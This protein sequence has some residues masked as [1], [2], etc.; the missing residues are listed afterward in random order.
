M[1][2]DSGSAAALKSNIDNLLY[3]ADTLFLTTVDGPRVHLIKESIVTFQGT[4]G[5]QKN[6]RLKPYFDR[7]IQ[8]LIEAG[9][10]DYHNKIFAKDMVRLNPKKAND[11]ISFSLDSLQ[12]AFYLFTFGVVVSTLIFILEVVCFHVKRRHAKVILVEQITSQ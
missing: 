3:I 1:L 8:R 5:L 6:F 7:V 10:T 9:I 12:G 2:L 4:F 11:R